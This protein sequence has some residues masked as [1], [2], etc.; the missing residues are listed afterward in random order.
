MV[1]YRRTA[2]HA[3]LAR[4]AASTNGRSCIIAVIGLGRGRLAPGPADGHRLARHPG[5]CRGPAL[6]AV[7][8]AGPVLHPVHGR[9]P[10]GGHP[11][12]GDD[13]AQADAG[14]PSAAP[15]ETWTSC[16]VAVPCGTAFGAAAAQGRAA[17]VR[18][19]RCRHSSSANSRAL[20]HGR[21]IVNVI[22]VDFR[23][24]DTLG[25][26]AVVMTAGLAILALIRVQDM[27]DRRRDR[28]EGGAT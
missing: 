22:I 4:P 8:R 3:G 1:A 7:R 18:R 28:T 11:R 26:I 23:G 19:R 13:A 16:V 12:A 10:V 2:R 6:P 20:A 9:D 24:L 17:A 5:L 14:R 21:N 25:E 15:R 27:P